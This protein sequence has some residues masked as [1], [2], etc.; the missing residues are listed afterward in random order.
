MDK[1]I[2]TTTRIIMTTTL[3][4]IQQGINTLRDLYVLEQLNERNESTISDLAVKHWLSTASLT[5]IVDKMVVRGFAE[6]KRSVTDRRK[7]FVNITQKG[8][9]ALQ[10]D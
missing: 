10:A 5:D 4:H 2:R 7:V 6:R 1:E 8:R 9:D 3:K